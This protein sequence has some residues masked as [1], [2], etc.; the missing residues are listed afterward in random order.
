LEGEEDWEEGGNVALEA[1]GGG[2]AAASLK[3]VAKRCPQTGQAMSMPPTL[4]GKRSAWPQPGQ[5][6]TG[7][8]LIAPPMFDMMQKKYPK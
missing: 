6:R 1:R 3:G 8:S 7:P 4:P 2:V 5:V